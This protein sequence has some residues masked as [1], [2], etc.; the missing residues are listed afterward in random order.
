MNN[1]FSVLVKRYLLAGIIVL[2][3]IVM[4]ILGFSTHQDGLF[5]LAAV[6]LLIG[7][8][9]AVLFSAGILSRNIVLIIGFV[10]IA[11]AIFVGYKTTKS[12][13]ITIQHEKDYTKSERL[14]QY[15][16]GQIRD[17]Q[18]SYRS[19]NGVY[20]PNF[21]ALIDFFENDKIQ[22]ID[23][24]GT[25]PARKMTIVERDFLYKDK[26]ALDQNMTER[27]AALL[28]AG[29]NPQNAADL[30]NFKRDTIQ[31]FYKDEFLSSKTRHSQREALGLG[32]FNINELRYIPMTNPKEE[33]TIDTRDQ[34][35]YLKGDT[36]PTIHVYGKEAIPKFEGG[37]RGIVGFG[38][39]KTNSDKGTWE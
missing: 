14:N 35:P 10:C 29:G 36:I 27:E 24:A 12:V 17:I 5:M 23:A 31:V 19:E 28:A 2:T 21:D 9:L 34:V 7:G 25:V 26:R 15:V 22:K 37:E 18:R 33:W 16:L 4:I 8:T 11:T 30:G 20:A 3:G 32:E 6:N 39:L 13:E 38:N 1:H